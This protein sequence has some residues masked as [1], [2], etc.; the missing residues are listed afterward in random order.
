ML[1]VLKGQCTRLTMDNNYYFNIYAPHTG[2]AKIVKISALLL[3]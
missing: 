2:F 3:Q 1:H